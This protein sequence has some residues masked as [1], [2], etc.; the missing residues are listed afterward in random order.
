[1]GRNDDK[2]RKSSSPQ[3]N[4]KTPVTKSNIAK[5]KA[6]VEKILTLTGRSHSSSPSSEEAGNDVESVVG[7]ETMTADNENPSQPE[8]T[9]TD[10]LVKVNQEDFPPLVKPSGH[11]PLSD[12]NSKPP[13]NAWGKK[14][15]Q[16]RIGM[17][18]PR[19]LMIKL[20][21]LLVEQLPVK[22]RSF[23][24]DLFAPS[25]PHTIQPQ[26]AFPLTGKLEDHLAVAAKATRF[27]AFP[28][29]YGEGELTHEQNAAVVQAAL[30]S[31]GFEYGVVVTIPPAITDILPPAK[32]PFYLPDI[33]RRLNSHPTYK[34]S[35]T[36]SSPIQL[37][38]LC[39]ETQSWEP[40]SSPPVP[41]QLHIYAKSTTPHAS[42]VQK[43]THQFI[44]E[45]VHHLRVVDKN[46]T[47]TLVPSGCAAHVCLQGTHWAK[48]HVRKALTDIGCN[49]VQSYALPSG[50]ELL[51]FPARFATPLCTKLPKIPVLY[52][53]PSLNDG[54]FAAEFVSSSSTPFDIRKLIDEIPTICYL[55]PNG[56]NKWK[57]ILNRPTNL[58]DWDSLGKKLG[59]KFFT[60]KPLNSAST[61]HTAMKEKLHSAPHI[62]L[63]AIPLHIP[64]VKIAEHLASAIGLDKTPFYAS[65]P[66][67]PSAPLTRGIHIFLSPD[68]VTPTILE[69]I[70]KKLSSTIC[71]YKE[72]SEKE[73]AS[74]LTEL[75]GLY[76]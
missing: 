68:V 71:T 30:D 72:P 74:A 53:A 14:I 54:L 62:T 50:T 43:I 23:D 59:G 60:P 25:E 61:S 67:I 29:I 73:L 8:T 2:K 6:M 76:K 55:I 40:T 21:P 1:M 41:I 3:P 13:G 66:T 24:T 65:D 26:T 35:Y 57:F 16:P 46:P 12:N 38:A 70:N 20:I 34:G 28:P 19:R 58:I 27:F 44:V 75:W 15:K 32:I 5:K 31:V 48:G 9:R 49:L 63:T 11:P 7:M 4:V 45:D 17:A 10:S 37:F 22:F 39:D 36:F 69:D 64:P 18:L 51:V 56:K 47:H 42:P 52:H 33:A